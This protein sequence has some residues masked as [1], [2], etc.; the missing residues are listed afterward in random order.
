MAFTSTLTIG[1][2]R[3]TKPFHMYVKK[4]C[5]EN[6]KYRTIPLV[7]NF[8]VRMCVC[9]FFERN[10]VSHMEC[11]SCLFCF[12]FSF[13]NLFQARHHLKPLFTRHASPTPP[14]SP[15]SHPPLHTHVHTDTALPPPSLSKTLSCPSCWVF[16]LPSDCDQNQFV[17]SLSLPGTARNQQ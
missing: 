7:A 6:D 5:G 2:Q 16:I 10:R 3:V 17:R 8:L 4:I 14:P 11:L 1:G 13:F 12:G 15:F 9:F